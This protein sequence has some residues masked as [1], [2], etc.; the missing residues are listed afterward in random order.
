MMKT[1]IALTKDMGDDEEFVLWADVQCQNKRVEEL[2][3]FSVDD[4]FQWLILCGNIPMPDVL[5]E[6]LSALKTDF[7]Q[8]QERFQ[9]END[10]LHA[11]HCSQWLRYIVG[12]DE[13][14]DNPG[15]RTLE[16]GVIVCTAVQTTFFSRIFF[17]AWQLEDL[18]ASDQEAHIRH[19]NNG[20]RSMQFFFHGTTGTNMGEIITEWDC[21]AGDINTR[22]FAIKCFTTSER[23][24]N[25]ESHNAVECILDADLFLLSTKSRHP[26]LK[27]MWQQSKKQPK[28]EMRSLT[29]ITTRYV[30]K[31]IFVYMNYKQPAIVRNIHIFKQL[32]NR[33]LFCTKFT[34]VVETQVYPRVGHAKA[35]EISGQVLEMMVIACCSRTFDNDVDIQL[36]LNPCY[37]DGCTFC[38]GVNNAV[39]SS[40]K[41]NVSGRKRK[42][43]WPET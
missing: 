27:N 38:Q 26:M 17:S 34:K 25:H 28:W 7:A 11:A 30:S 10:E 1:L 3:F 5:P 39:Q 13:F 9:R 14:K 23:L 21:M 40:N 12:K 42:R 4:F 20:F 35:K 41:E 19:V 2:I 31:R 15:K 6:T 18:S 8:M 16:P 43:E 33:G 37:F 29:A 22:T 36:E 24:R 32:P